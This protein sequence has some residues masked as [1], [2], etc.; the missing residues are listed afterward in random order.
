MP[1]LNREK[2]D[3]D[4]DDYDVIGRGDLG[5]LSCRPAATVS[6]EGRG[7]GIGCGVVV[8]NGRARSVGPKPSD[9]SRGGQLRHMTAAATRQPTAF[10]SPPSCPTK[11]VSVPVVD[12]R[13]IHRLSV[14]PPINITRDCDY[15]FSFIQNLFFFFFKFQCPVC[16]SAR[17]DLTT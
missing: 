7:R 12:R 11:N 13:I 3:D 4:D 10:S 8:C 5:L 2:P 6:G 15:V 14:R 1:S 17:R 16:C 9:G